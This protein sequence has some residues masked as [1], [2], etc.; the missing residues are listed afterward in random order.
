MFIYKIIRFLKKRGK[1]LANKLPSYF[2]RYFLE[3]KKF[4]II[5]DNCWGSFT[6]QYFDIPYNTPFV[7]LYLFSPDYI[8]LLKNLKGYLDLEIRFIHPSESNY[9]DELIKNQTFG[10]YPIGVLNDVE[11][12]FLHYKSEQ[13]AK[14]KWTRRVSRIDYNNLIVKF[15]DRDLASEEHILEFAKLDYERKV[16]LTAKSYGTQVEIVLGNENGA[17]IE[18]EWANYLET[19]KPV[20]LF[21]SFKY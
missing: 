19:I 18:D 8:R 20:K 13:Q 16:L 21:N 11:I 7:G 2:R 5:S 9:K 3:N 12:H 10:T 4:C 14:E 1:T 6:Y 15:C 17:F